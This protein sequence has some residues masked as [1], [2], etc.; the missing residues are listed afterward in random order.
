MNDS[1]MRLEMKRG[2]DI[3]LNSAN[4]LDKGE[5]LTKAGRALQKHGE[6]L[7][8]LFPKPK[9]NPEVINKQASTI[10][11]EILGNPNSIITQR[12]HARFGEITDIYAP[13]GRGI[14]YD[15][16]NNFIG[17]IEKGN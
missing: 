8:S 5:E 12:H 11:E 17:L 16:Q 3:L 7:G 1:L 9:G 2:R 13:D 10:V 4:T 15:L 6:R 14:R